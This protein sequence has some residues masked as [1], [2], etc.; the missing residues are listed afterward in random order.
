MKKIVMSLLDKR[1][2][3]LSRLN[4]YR[5]VN[6]LTTENAV[7]GFEIEVSPKAL[8]KL[9]LEGKDVFFSLEHDFG[10]EDKSKEKYWVRVANEY[11]NKKTDFSYFAT[12]KIRARQHS[13]GDDWGIQVVFSHIDVSCNWGQLNALCE[14]LA[15]FVDQK[16][17]EDCGFKDSWKVEI[18]KIDFISNK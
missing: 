5:K 7:G 15:K 13:G 6:C 2:N 10:I 8:N 12:G 11:P 1:T 4:E 14:M 17:G 18:M 9:K 3:R 16:Y